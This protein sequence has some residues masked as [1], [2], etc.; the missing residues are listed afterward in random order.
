[1]KNIL[2]ARCA[3][4]ALALLGFF[5]LVY[6]QTT[7]PPSKPPA[8]KPAAGP[9]ADACYG[10]HA[11]IKDFHAGS[12][13][14]NIACGSC[15]EGLDKHLQ[16]FKA[17]PATLTD[18][19]VCGKCHQPQYDSM[20]KMNWEKT[21]MNEKSQ[22]KGTAPGPAWEMLMMPH[23]FT[24]EHN[25]PRSHAFALYDQLVVDRA[26]GGRF[27]PKT[28]WQSLARPAGNFKLWDVL[29]DRFAGQDNPPLRAGTAAAGNPVCLSCKTQ[30]HILDWA[31]MGDPVPGAKW[32]RTSRV[33]D[34][35][36][37]VNHSVNCFFCH[38]P[39]SAKPRI[40]RDGLIDALTRPEKDTLWHEDPRAGKI[41][42]KDMGL[43]G[44]TRKIATLDR[45]DNNLQ[46]GQCHVEYNCNPGTDPT[47][48]KPVTMAD[49]RANHFPFKKVEDIAKHYNDLKF[50]D[51][52]HGITGALLWKGQHPDVEN[53]Y[54][55][56][57][58][59]AGV[60][61]SSCH[62]PKMK[63]PKTGRTF[64]SHWQTSPRHYVKET[65]LQC[66]RDWSQQQVVYVLD[67]LKNRFQGKLR[68]AEFW[69]TR[70]VDQFDQARAL[71]V[72]ESILNQ[73]R[74]KHYEAQ[75]NWEWWTAS[76]GAHF[77]NP[78]EA[79]ASLNKSIAISQEGLKIL[80]DAMASKRTGSQARSTPDAQQ[81]PAP[82]PR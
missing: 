16:D 79:V 54:Q 39:H 52:R 60:E 44:Y 77:H 15:H 76:N 20:Y 28:G 72:D 64:T 50:R 73:V 17:R 38:D 21:A 61:C 42:V 4:V 81:Q 48:G 71:Q 23:G 6:A 34:M 56:K 31:Y 40:V 46:C 5:G 29:E 10:C 9:A 7:P 12:K 63:D 8:A 57:H 11:P 26:F 51:F 27:S 67:S 18:P 2:R 70:M 78:D 33:V 66:H 32:S 19:A 14:Q 43:R 80:E 36:K 58:Q 55:T 74:E 62:M 75:I 22:M 69:L 1:M 41:E 25:E 24:R 37:A 65:C 45:Y 47:T 59:K 13:H 35:V 53:Y 49:R 82:A 30:D 68:K 3:L